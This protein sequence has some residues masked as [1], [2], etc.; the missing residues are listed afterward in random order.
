MLDD[1]FVCSLLLACVAAGCSTSSSLY[2]DVRTDLRPGD[3]FVTT[4]TT[5]IGASAAG[6]TEISLTAAIGEDDRYI[7]GLRAAEFSAV[8]PSTFSIRVSLIT[9]DGSVLV[10]TGSDPG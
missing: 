3:E 2:V 1:R 6:T 8:T 9:Q 7:A 4:R 10:E 5:R